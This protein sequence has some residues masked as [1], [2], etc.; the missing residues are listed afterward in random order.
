MACLLFKTQYSANTFRQKRSPI[1]LHPA[2]CLRFRLDKL[3]F[4][5]L[6]RRINNNKKQ[7]YEKFHQHYSN[8]PALHPIRL[9]ENEH[10]LSRINRD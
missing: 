5:T 6:Y 7:H 3:L 1:I 2:L 4:L 8:T 10:K 9:F